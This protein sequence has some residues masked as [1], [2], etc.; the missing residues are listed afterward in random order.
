MYA[1]SIHVSFGT[2]VGT[3]KVLYADHGARSIDIQTPTSLRDRI[4]E[5]VNESITIYLKANFGSD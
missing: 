5:Y 1:A 2:T 4:E 3:A